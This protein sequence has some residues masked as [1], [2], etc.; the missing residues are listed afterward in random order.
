MR[1][2]MREATRCEWLLLAVLVG[3]VE[4][5]PDAPPSALAPNALHP[6]LTIGE[7][8]SAATHS[9]YSEAGPV[10]LSDMRVVVADTRSMRIRLLDREGR[11]IRTA[12]RSGRGPGEFRSISWLGRLPNDSV[13]AFDFRLSQFSVFDS[14]AQFIRSFRLPSPE[15]G[16][17]S[18]PAPVAVTV[19]GQVILVGNGSLTPPE[20]S[21]SRIDSTAIFILDPVAEVLRL[22]GRFATVVTYSPGTSNRFVTIVPFTSRGLFSVAPGGFAY[23]HGSRASVEFYSETGVLQREVKLDLAPG[24]PVTDRLVEAHLERRISESPRDWRESLRSAFRAMD[25][26]DVTPMFDR[27][28][29]SSVGEIWIRRFHDGGESAT[30]WQV[31]DGTGGLLRQFELPAAYVVLEVRGTRVVGRWRA[32]SGVEMAGVFTVE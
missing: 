10:L 27:L 21:G 26:P 14:N 7:L 16:R 8:E 28:Y 24:Q 15:S 2:V 17:L 5:R 31:F 29:V 9:D 1:K 19:H 32:D 30:T 25:L 23:G 20:R 11:V 18:W 4:A 6:Q 3:C 22:V 12:G 13:I